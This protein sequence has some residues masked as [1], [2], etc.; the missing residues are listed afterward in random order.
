MKPKQYGKLLARYRVTDGT[1][2]RLKDYPPDDRGGEPV[3]SDELDALLAEDVARLAA[4]QEILYADGR[5]SLL[6][7]FQGMDASGKDGTIRHVMTGVNPQGI[8][9]TSFKAPGPEA[10]AHDFL[11]RVHAAVPERG[12]I[13]IFNRSHYEDVLVTR[14]H[15]DLLDRAH[16]PSSVRG[17]KF[18]QHRLEDIAAFERYLSRQGVIVLKFYLNLS[19][20]E[21]KRRFLA[22]IDHAHKNWK[23]TEA[24]LHERAFFDQ[25]HTAFAAAIEA[26]AVPHAPWYVVPADHKKFAHLVV[27]AAILH[28]L[29]KLDLKVPVL[30]PAERE[31][32]E[33]A[34][35]AL[36]AE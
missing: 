10:L 23:F 14:V 32:L 17:K 22:R 5:W 34:R 9:V 15:P 30:P 13:G 28:A 18:W 11:W 29:E 1:K 6:C 26:T 27:V 8:T 7:V 4:L 36:E 21:Q 24:D 20:D 33:A 35:A 3:G 31:L 2:F 16:L 25:Y 12:H 19:K